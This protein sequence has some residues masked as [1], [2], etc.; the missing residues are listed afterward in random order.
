MLRPVNLLDAANAAKALFEYVPV[1]MCNGQALHVLQAENRTL[2]FHAH[3]ESD[4]LFY[5]L[6]GEFALELDDGLVPLR[7]GDL[8]VVPRGTRHRPVC[9]SLVKCLLM[10][11][12]G[13]LN[14]GNT[15]G[16]YIS[17]E[18]T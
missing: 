8:I 13:T 1:G 12:G 11:R 2:D 18:P 4:E 14:P 15:G 3:E 17:K 5:V 6:E 7:Q 16:S 9:T 10:E